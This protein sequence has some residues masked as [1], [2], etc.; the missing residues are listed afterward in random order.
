[1]GIFLILS[2]MRTIL[3]LIQIEGS[4]FELNSFLLYINMP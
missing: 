4:S 1:M 3:N 2:R